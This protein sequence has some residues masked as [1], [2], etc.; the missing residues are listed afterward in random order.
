MRNITRRDAVAGATGIAFLQT[1]TAFGAQA[2]SAIAFGIIGTGARGQYVGGHMARDGRSHDQ[3]SAVYKEG[4]CKP[5][6]HRVSVLSDPRGTCAGRRGRVIRGWSVG[7]V[8]N[9][10]AT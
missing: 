4:D 6:H 3:E 7:R 10:H 8:E 9:F 5:Q 2:N 1:S